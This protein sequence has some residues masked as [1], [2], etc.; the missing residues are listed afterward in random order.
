VGKFFITIMVCCC[1]VCL[2]SCDQ[3]IRQ[4]NDKDLV[5]TKIFANEVDTTRAIAYVILD[6]EAFANMPVS[7]LEYAK[8][9][10]LITQIKPKIAP[11]KKYTKIEAIAILDL[12][13]RSVAQMR[14]KQLSYGSTLYNSLRFQ[15]FDCDINSFLFLTVAHELNLPIY[16]VMMPNHVA[17]LWQ[18]NNYEILWETTEGR[19]RTKQYYTKK[20]KLNKEL[21]ATQKMLKPLNKKDLIAVAWFNI[22][23]AYTDA[24]QLKQA[25]WASKEAIKWQ[26]N[27]YQPY[28]NLARTMAKQKN[29]EVA[30]YYCHYSLGLYPNQLFLLELKAKCFDQLGCNTEAIAAYKTYR[31]SLPKTIHDYEGVKAKIKEKIRALDK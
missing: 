26:P 5:P 22:A 15:L 19:P 7:E 9:R 30:L 13:D 23:K 8:V 16:A 14:I 25:E 4:Q 2:F 20:Y 11:K 17:I 21:I 1:I 6:I 18:N 3:L 31:N 10:Q 28:T 12:I 29:D 27:W 24:E